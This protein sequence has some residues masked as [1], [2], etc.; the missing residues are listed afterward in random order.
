MFSLKN[1]FNKKTA[2]GFLAATVILVGGFEGLRT[3]AYKDS[4]GVPTI[5]YGETK[6]VRMGQVKTVSECNKMF[7]D[8]LLEFYKGV[9]KCV[10]VEMPD[11]VKIAFTSLA[12]NIGLGAFCKSTLV[13]K[14]NKNDLKGAC[15]EIP[16]WNRGSIPGQGRKVLKGLT[17]RRAEEK[18]LCLSSLH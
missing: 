6:G 1:L 7:E 18:K 13:K 15:N 5:C 14:A 2:T 10:T 9:D 11:G 16:K 4:V 3:R 8:R 17:N 12:Y